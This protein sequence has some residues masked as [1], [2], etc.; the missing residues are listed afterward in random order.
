MRFNAKTNFTEAT[1]LKTSATYT[2]TG[3]NRIR[4]GAN[5]SGLYLGLLRN[6]VDFDIS[7]YRGD[8]YASDDSAP[9]PNRHRSYREPIGA[10]G[11]ATYNNPLWTI[12][13]QENKAKVDRFITNF[14]FM[15]APKS[16]LTFIARA[17]VD[18]YSETKAEFI[19]LGSAS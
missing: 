18:H 1:S 8:Y 15:T 2:R 14:E 3:S 19:I 7:G 11:T 13:E 9:I 17:G 4:L 10:D 16:W 12:N 6:P 5:S